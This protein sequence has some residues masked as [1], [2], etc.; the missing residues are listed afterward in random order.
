MIKIALIF[1][2]FFQPLFAYMYSYIVP[3]I[4]LS[5]IKLNQYVD[6]R[7]NMV[8]TKLNSIEN[9]VIENIQEEVKKKKKNTDRLRN[10]S[11]LDYVTNKEFLF[12]VKKINQLTDNSIDTKN[13]TTPTPTIIHPTQGK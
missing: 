10:I 7:S 1:T 6:Q 4:N 11:K 12:L 9:G 13:A 8:K 5:L 2:L 3:D